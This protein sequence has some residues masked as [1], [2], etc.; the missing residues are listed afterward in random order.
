MKK[1]VLIAVPILILAVLGGL[2]AGG[3]IKL[4]FMAKKPAKMYGEA[5]DAKLAKSKEKPKPIVVKPAP[6]PAPATPAPRFEPVRGDRRLAKVWN[7]MEP[8][9][10]LRLTDGWNERDLVGVMLAMNDPQVAALLTE[11]AAPVPRPPIAL[12][13][14]PANATEADRAAHEALRRQRADEQEA[15]LKSEDAARTRR[16]ASLSRALRRE[17]SLVTP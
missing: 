13:P 17:A 14:L 5:K 10:V 2:V 11:M 3:V 7:Q 8:A 6:K 16:A 4:P 15:R 1:G 12:P 9:D